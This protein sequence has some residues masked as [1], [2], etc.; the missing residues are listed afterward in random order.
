MPN[1]ACAQ[2]ITRWINFVVDLFVLFAVSNKCLACHIYM[3]YP[4]ILHISHLGGQ[5]GKHEG[6]E[7]AD[8]QISL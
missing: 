4:G 3:S 5:E 6:N 8:E 1:D 2:N 7:G